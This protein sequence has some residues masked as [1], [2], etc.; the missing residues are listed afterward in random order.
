MGALLS[1]T[2]SV[3][4]IRRS[5]SGDNW[6]FS[7]SRRNHCRSASF[8]VTR[9]SPNNPL[10]NATL[11]WLIVRGHRRP[12]H[13]RQSQSHRRCTGCAYW[14]MG[15]V[16]IDRSDPFLNWCTTRRDLLDA[17]NFRLG[18]TY[19]TWSGC[20]NRSVLLIFSAQ[21]DRLAQFTPNCS[22]I[23]SKVFLCLVPCEIQY[24]TIY[25]KCNV[26]FILSF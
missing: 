11:I 23:Y 14:P 1:K 21:T 12:N 7:E 20:L 17:P 5:C 9:P 16:C 2:A 19:T 13:R 10:H 6:L 15:P 26:R 25:C 4:E 24:P 3:P 18:A 8:P 22:G